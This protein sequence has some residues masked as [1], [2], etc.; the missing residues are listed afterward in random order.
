MHLQPITDNL[1]FMRNQEWYSFYAI[2]ARLE[3]TNS[4]YFTP[5]SVKYC[6]PYELIKALC[7]EISPPYYECKNLD[8]EPVRRDP[9]GGHQRDAQGGRRRARTVLRP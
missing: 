8:R 7:N 3:K 6:T 1:R 4:E 9:A 5:S 2:L